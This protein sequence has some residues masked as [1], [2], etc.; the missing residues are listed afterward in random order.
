MTTNSIPIIS[1]KSSFYGYIVGL[2]IE[3]GDLD[4]S[5]ECPHRMFARFEYGSKT[6]IFEIPDHELFRILSVF[7]S[8]EAQIRNVS[9]SRLNKLWIEKLDGKWEVELP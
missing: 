9:E 2:Q 5:P 6:K 7:L 8:D 1:E 3:R 4:S